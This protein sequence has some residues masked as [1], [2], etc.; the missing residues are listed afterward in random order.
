MSSTEDAS[1]LHKRII[2]GIDRG[3]LYSK[4]WYFKRFGAQ[5]AKDDGDVLGHPKTTITTNTDTAPPEGDPAADDSE[6][7][8]DAEP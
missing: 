4:E 3:V 7:V 1:A 2:D 6:D 5:E 8:G